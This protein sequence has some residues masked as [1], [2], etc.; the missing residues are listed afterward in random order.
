[1]LRE[2]ASYH[3]SEGTVIMMAVFAEDVWSLAII[4]PREMKC[5]VFSPEWRMGYTQFAC[6]AAGQCAKD[7][8]GLHEP[9]EFFS[10]RHTEHVPLDWPASR[11]IVWLAANYLDPSIRA[12]T[13]Q[14]DHLGGQAS[15]GIQRDAGQSS[16]T[17][18]GVA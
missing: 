14:L 13:F 2:L 4:Q 9:L 15:H 10:L 5:Y 3:A 1:L 12:A 17:M 16:G 6:L 7:V 11:Y 8:L 18:F